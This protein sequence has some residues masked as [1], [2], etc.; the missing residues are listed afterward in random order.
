[1][2]KLNVQRKVV[3]N[4]NEL[5]LK[6]TYWA[7]ISG[8]KDSLFMLKLILKHP[9][10]YPLNGV[11][12]FDLEIDY[13]FIKDVISKIKAECIRLKIPMFEI[14]PRQTWMTLYE[15]Y[16]YPT[17]VARW[18]N[19]K[20]KLDCS[21]QFEQMQR[22]YG[23]SVNWYIGYCYDEKARYEKRTN[24]NEIYPLVDYE[25]NESWILEWA[26][27]QTIFNNYYLTNDRCG[28]MYCPMASKLNFAYLYKYYPNEFNKMIELMKNTE[29]K[30]SERFNRKFSVTSSNPKYDAIY[31]DNIIKT[32]WINKLNE[33]EKNYR[34]K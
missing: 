32:K 18:C 9:E 5:E 15:K 23:N 2:F 31:L 3:H 26:R 30:L 33:L 24:K 19:N 27:E 20:Y 7:S 29:I 22:Q 14:K 11:V 34:Y 17:R 10:K 12:Y 16:G 28:C 25:I 21:D 6:P 4:M 8:G 13:P 1:M